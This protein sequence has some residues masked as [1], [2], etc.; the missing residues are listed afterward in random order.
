MLDQYTDDLDAST[1]IYY[2]YITLLLV[3][4]IL[5]IAYLF[6]DFQEIIYSRLR[7]V[8]TK[9]ITLSLILN[10]ITT[11]IVLYWLYKYLYEYTVNLDGIDSQRKVKTIIDRIEGDSYFHLELSVAF[12]TSIQ[13]AR[14]IFALQMSRVFGP[15]VKILGNMLVDLV[16]FIFMYLLVFLIFT[17]ASQLLFHTID[18]YGT[19][20]DCSLTMFSASLGDFDFGVF[21]NEGSFTKNVGYIFLVIYLTVST[22]TLLNFLIAILSNT[23]DFLQSHKNALYLREVILLRQK[24]CFNQK[25]SSIVSAFVPLNIFALLMD[26]F[27]ICLKSKK[28][29]YLCLVFEYVI[30]GLLSIALFF[31]ISVILIPISYVILVMNKLKYCFQKPFFGKQDFVMRVLDL[32]AITIVGFFWL[33]LLLVWNTLVYAWNLLSEDIKLVEENDEE[34]LAHVNALKD[35]SIDYSKFN[36]MY[37]EPMGGLD[38]KNSKEQRNPVYK[39][40]TSGNVGNPIK[41]GISLT[42]LKLLK[43]TLI[44]MK[45]DYLFLAKKEQTSVIMVPVE[46]V[47]K[48]MYKNLCIQEH[49]NQV[50]LGIH[51][52]KDLSFFESSRFDRIIQGFSLYEERESKVPKQNLNFKNLAKGIFMKTILKKRNDIRGLFWRNKLKNFIIKSDEKWILDQY[53][54]IKRFCLD[55]SVEAVPT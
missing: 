27:I 42:T 46:V 2:E 34:K 8:Y 1:A 29:N 48:E 45:E 32:I 18:G 51:Y 39:N 12:L 7:G 3:I 54:L 28:L 4:H 24:Y 53:N 35:G 26:P 13:Y 47:I 6:Q 43:M 50:C 33:A 25:Y 49:I 15:M 36:Q 11:V 20:I 16:I 21:A 10:I 22:I 37:G 55:N 5:T 52:E 41:E 19:F 38:T 17:C 40:D 30:L 14:M 31:A 9:V 44:I 23:Y